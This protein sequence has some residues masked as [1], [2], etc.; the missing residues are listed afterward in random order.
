MTKKSDALPVGPEKSALVRAMFDNI[1]ERYALMNR[2]ITFG[3]DATWRRKTIRLLGL[4]PHAKV[5]DIGCGTGE[6]MKALSHADIKAVGV[7]L[8][9][10][11]LRASKE[12]TKAVMQADAGMLPISSGSLDGAVSGFAV[13]NFADLGA[14][15]A[16]I[17]RALRPGGR[18]ALLEVDSPSSPLLRIGHRI[19]FTTV[20]PF[21]GALLSDK[22]AYRYLP[23]SVAYLPNATTFETLL[24]TAGFTD[25]EH[26]ALSGGVVQVIVATRSFHTGS[27]VQHSGL[28][29]PSGG[30]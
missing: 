24:H 4:A 23:R 3:L 19:W 6:L 9:M 18:I 26:K 21:L 7:D 10:E 25:M 16:E 5:A 8:S 28:V 22:Y 20:V 14:V 27:E 15:F 30:N 12:R 1:A 11:M 2:L 29:V 13:R 17:S